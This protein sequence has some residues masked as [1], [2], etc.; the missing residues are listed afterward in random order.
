M[1]GADTSYF[2]CVLLQSE[3]ERMAT[4]HFY[5]FS[6][7]LSR[8][9][10]RHGFD[11]SHCLI[12]Q[13]RINRSVYLNVTYTAVFFHDKLYNNPSLNAFSCANTGYLRLDTIN[14]F[15]ALVPPGKEGCWSTSSPLNILLLSLSFCSSLLLLS[16]SFCSFLN[17]YHYLPFE[18]INIVGKILIV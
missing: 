3:Y 16:F 6:I 17:K 12:V 4:F 8:N 18:H 2:L 13:T 5:G 1:A 11:Y 9:P 10:F 15:N 14:V 7:Y